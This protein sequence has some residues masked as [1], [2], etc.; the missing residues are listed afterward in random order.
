MIKIGLETQ[1]HSNIALP[2][3]S[4]KTNSLHRQIS[5]VSRV[6]FEYLDLGSRHVADLLPDVCSYSIQAPYTFEDLYTLLMGIRVCLPFTQAPNGEV[7]VS[8][9]TELIAGLPSSSC[10]VILHN[11]A[12]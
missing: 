1:S 2:F 3:V 4:H 11:I 9:R 12:S 10:P 6:P 8:M 5:T 7:S